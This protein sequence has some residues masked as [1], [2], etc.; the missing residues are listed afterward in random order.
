MTPLRDDELREMLRRWEASPVPASLEARVFGNQRRVRAG[1]LWGAVRVPVPALVL[2]AAALV[3]LATAEVHRQREMRLPQ[4]M[5]DGNLIR[6]PGLEGVVKLRIHIDS[7]GRV[8]GTTALRG[9]PRLVPAAIDAAKQRV[10]RPALLNGNPIAVDTQVE[11]S[12]RVDVN[13]VTKRG[14]GQ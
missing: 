12:F 3:G 8:T 13:V 7:D 14:D 6:A 1:W 9:D 11:V 4:G 10:Y 5:V 2:A